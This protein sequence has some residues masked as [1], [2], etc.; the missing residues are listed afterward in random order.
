M[1]SAIGTRTLVQAL[2]FLIVARVLGIAEYGAYTAVLALATALSSLGGMGVYS[3]M[4]REVSRNPGGFPAA[5]GQTLAAILLSTPPLFALYLALAW[6]LIPS[7]IS[8]PVTLLIGLSELAFT[9][10]IVAA[11]HA[12]Q[13]QGHIGRAS[14]VFFLPVAPRLVSALLLVLLTALFPKEYHLTAWAGLYAV[15]T[16]IAAEYARRWV[17][18]DLGA[19]HLPT[20]ADGW[21]KLAEGFPFAVG[22]AALKLYTDIDKT[23]LARLSTLEA[24]GAYSASHRVVDLAT[25]PALSLMI[26]ATPRFFREGAGGV[27]QALA[28]ARRILPLPLAFTLGASIA[29]YLCADLLPWLLGA[30]YAAAVPALRWLAWLPC[31]SLPRLFLQTLLIGSDRQRQVVGVLLVGAMINIGLNLWLIPGWGWQGAVIAT[32]GAEAIMAGAMLQVALK[33]AGKP[34]AA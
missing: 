21:A 20:L 26:A 7:T 25:V 10:I 8:F 32:Y 19:A 9:P 2:V 6:W 3:V 23:M 11:I 14:G 24:T 18:R 17:R 1:A 34:L 5:W 22:T 27:P 29:I 16:L 33:A 31:A 15:A 28:F 4:V 13:S 12:F 30:G